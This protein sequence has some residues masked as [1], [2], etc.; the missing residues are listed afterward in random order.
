[1][2]TAAAVA[3]SG[4]LPVRSNLWYSIS[5]FQFLGLLVTNKM[6]D[7]LYPRQCSAQ[8]LLIRMTFVQIQI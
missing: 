7:F 6:R 8:L 1:M 5:K 4:Q 3:A 2:N